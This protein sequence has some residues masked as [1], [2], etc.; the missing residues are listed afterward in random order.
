MD[1]RQQLISELVDLGNEI[2]WF[3]RPLL[4]QAL[5]DYSLSEIEL[6]EKIA[7]INHAN[8]TKLAAAS[9]MTRGAISKQ[10]KKL[11][12]KGLIESYQLGDNKKEIYFKLTP[13]GTKIN[14]VHTDLHKSFLKRDE[15]IFESMSDEDYHTIF[16]FIG[17][18][19]E[20]LKS[21]AEK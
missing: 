4:E 2:E 21:I 19:R 13:Q 14:Q 7:L 17:R 18:Y 5:K 10:T 15:K 16:R 11:Q 6:I 3:N 20:H 9:F 8:V 12:S 1:K